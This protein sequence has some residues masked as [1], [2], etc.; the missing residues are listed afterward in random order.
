MR[1]AAY[2]I[3]GSVMAMSLADL[4]KTPLAVHYGALT[5]LGW[6]VW[7]LLVRAFPA[8]VKSQREDRAAFLVAQKEER[9]GFL[10]AQEATRRDFRDSLHC[11][12]EAIA[13]AR[14]EG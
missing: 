6:M 7:Y 2:G 13:E 14:R 3:F 8:H 5:I 1:L 9:E 4:T 12:T 11:M 10:E